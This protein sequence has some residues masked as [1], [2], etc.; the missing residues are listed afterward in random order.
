MAQRTA[1][2]TYR[3]GTKV[4]TADGRQ[5]GA[6]SAVRRDAVLVSSFDGECAW[7]SSGD[8]LGYDGECLTVAPK[9]IVP[10][11]EVP[12]SILRSAHPLIPTGML[13]SFTPQGFDA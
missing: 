2:W 1:F 6:V 11:A 7:V 13:R 3:A 4:R 9:V 10:S 5:V 12:L 8:V